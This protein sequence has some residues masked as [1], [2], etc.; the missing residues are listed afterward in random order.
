MTAQGPGHEQ[1]HEFSGLYVLG[2]LAAADRDTFERHLAEC[3]AC[4]DEVRSLRG[5]T[6][7]LP[8]GVPMIDPPAAL[9]AR[10]LAAAAGGRAPAGA[11][12]VVPLP[13]RS[14][15][16]PAAGAGF[17]A[18]FGW[19]SAAALF[20][21]ASG[22]G[23]YSWSLRQ[24]IGGLEERLQD[25]VTRLERS[26]QQVTVATR[27][28]ATAEGRLAVLTAPDM[29]QINLAGQPAAPRATGRAFWS[30]S[31]GLV[32]T[33]SDLPP[34]PAGRIYQVWMVLPGAPLSAGLIAPDTS[35]RA[36]EAF[37]TPPD[38]ETPVAVAVTIEP[39]GGL[40]APSGAFYLLGR[41]Q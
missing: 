25:A 35:G 12:Q 20:I 40:P 16:A 8:L 3:E 1:L 19:L 27:A 32:F 7:A 6:A 2:A 38:V 11:A 9:R 10:V 36:Q 14:T 34:L 18:A 17:A 23:F 13:Q 5:V 30:R 33:A 29:T 15:A 21:L 39:A 41:T 31:R 4:H 24:Q 22:L 28:V 26:E 37:D